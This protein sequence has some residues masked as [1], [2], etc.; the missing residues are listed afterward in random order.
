MRTTISFDDRL[1]QRVRRTA[2]ARGISVSDSIVKAL[3]DALIRRDQSEP[4]PFR[5][6]TV[7][8][9][10]LPLGVDLEQPRALDALDD[11]ARFGHGSR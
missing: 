11:E 1:A 10:H 7:R 9:V 8:G 6:V 2:K 5:L 4:L 3:D